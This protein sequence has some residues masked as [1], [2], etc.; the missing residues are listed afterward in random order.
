MKFMTKIFKKLLHVL[1]KK[2]RLVVVQ[3][4]IRW[5]AVCVKW[6]VCVCEG[7]VRVERVS[8]VDI[9]MWMWEEVCFTNKKY[10]IPCY[11]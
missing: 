3:N 2:I 9:V 7:Q 11:L 4:Y 6:R 1:A 5:H 8:S 10:S